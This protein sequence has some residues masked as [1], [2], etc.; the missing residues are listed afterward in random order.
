METSSANIDI[1]DT[2][3]V[4]PKQPVIDA[5]STHRTAISDSNLRKRIQQL[6]QCL[7]ESPTYE[8]IK[9]SSRKNGLNLAYKKGFNQGFD[10]LINGVTQTANEY[11]EEDYQQPV[12]QKPELSIFVSHKWHNS[13][14]DNQ[15]FREVISELSTQLKALPEQWH[16]QFSLRL[17]KDFEEFQAHKPRLPQQDNACQQ[18]ILALIFW[19]DGYQ[20][21]H[22]FAQ[23][24]GFF[25]DHQGSNQPEK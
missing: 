18:A 9:L 14:T 17:H 25:I 13:D 21:S 22:D 19:S 23:E 4:T 6:N 15:L 11:P 1:S 24:A 7:S 2:L 3:A 10:E 12:A 8:H 20:Q 5:M 16:N